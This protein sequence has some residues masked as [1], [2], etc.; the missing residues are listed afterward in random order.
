MRMIDADALLEAYDREHVGPPGRARAL[1]ENSPTIAEG[2]LTWHLYPKQ[3]PKKGGK[4]LVAVFFNEGHQEVKQA[5]YNEMLQVFEILYASDD[6]VYKW[7]EWPDTPA[8]PMEA[9][10]A[11]RVVTI[12]N[13]CFHCYRG[14]IGE[15]VSCPYFGMLSSQDL[16]NPCLTMTA[17]QAFQSYTKCQSWTEEELEDFHVNRNLPARYGGETVDNVDGEIEPE[18]LPF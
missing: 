1:I 3:A 18:D 8:L 5:K 13:P 4:Y 14:A 7:A 17:Q 16:E 12:D 9:I 15:C 10:D 11:D 2:V 6:M